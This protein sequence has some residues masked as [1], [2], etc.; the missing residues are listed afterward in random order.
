LKE[1]TD[2]KSESNSGLKGS[3]KTKKVEK[4]IFERVLRDK[5]MGFINPVGL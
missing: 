2:K 3:K 1:Y 5:Q 4:P